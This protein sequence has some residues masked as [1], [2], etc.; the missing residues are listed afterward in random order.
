MAATVN[1][2]FW[3]DLWAREGSNTNWK[4]SIPYLDRGWTFLK[5]RISCYLCLYMSS[6]RKRDHEEKTFDLI[7]R[8]MIEI[9]IG[10]TTGN[11][12]GMRRMLQFLYKKKKTFFTVDLRHICTTIVI[13]SRGINSG[14]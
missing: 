5:L 7:A 1:E 10:A 11:E 12:N 3:E 4:Y 14:R 13:L 2:I 9:K 8:T 6:T